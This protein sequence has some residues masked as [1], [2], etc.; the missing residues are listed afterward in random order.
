MAPS[1]LQARKLKKHPWVC[2]A[3]EKQKENAKHTEFLQSKA[4]IIP[5]NFLPSDT[6]LAPMR[7]SYV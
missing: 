3:W 7:D 2:L 1:K 6:M 4:I 5:L